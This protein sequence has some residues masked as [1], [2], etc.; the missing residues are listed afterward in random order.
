MPEL[1]PIFLW[2]MLTMSA[3]YLIGV[4]GLMLRASRLRRRILRLENTLRTIRHLT[5]HLGDADLIY[6]VDDLLAAVA[7]D[8]HETH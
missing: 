1:P 4:A 6:H 2:A 3:V 5:R 7:L 8:T